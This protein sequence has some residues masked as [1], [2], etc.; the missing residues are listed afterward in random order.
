MRGIFAIPLFLPFLASAGDIYEGYDAYYDSWPERLFFAQGFDLKAYSI[1]G[2]KDIHIGW[3]G[4]IQGHRRKIEIHNG[5]LIID[6]YV[7]KSRSISTFLGETLN[8]DEFG[9]G[10]TAFFAPEWVCVENTPM[11]AS[12]TAVR[13]KA[14][15]LMHL[16]S[17]KIQTWKLPSLFAACGGI[18]KKGPHV[19][20]ERVEYRYQPNQDD[21]VGVVFREYTIKGSS[22]F[23]LGRNRFATFI[24]PGNVYKFSIDE[25]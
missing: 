17:K 21:P 7:A 25:P 23:S 6:G 9:I 4:I 14:V 8:E 10:S 1:R 5:V 12:G 13:H 16:S 22:F 18:R 24:E 3:S 11:S 2:S 15:Y 20:F 19:V